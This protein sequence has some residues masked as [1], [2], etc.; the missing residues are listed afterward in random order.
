ARVPGAAR[1]HRHPQGVHPRG[2][3]HDVGPQRGVP[4]EKEGCWRRDG[5]NLMEVFA[6][7]EVDFTR[8][9][10]NSCVEMF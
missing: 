1:G 3:A 4:R 5:S 7:P 2:A 10:T 6:Y 9:F 8:S